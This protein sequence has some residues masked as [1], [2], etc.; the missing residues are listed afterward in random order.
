MVSY[1]RQYLNQG[2]VNALIGTLYFQ[3]AST[4]AEQLVQMIWSSIA[5]DLNNSGLNAG[6]SYGKY[7]ASYS[8]TGNSAME[9][10]DELDV[11]YD[12][13]PVI[14]QFVNAI[15]S[16]G[17][18]AADFNAC[19]DLLFAT[20]T[21]SDDIACSLANQNQTAIFVSC[22]ADDYLRYTEFKNRL[23]QMKVYL[24][25]MK[26]ELF[27]DCYYSYY[28]TYCGDVANTIGMMLPGSAPTQ[29]E[30]DERAVRL[31]DLKELILSSGDVTFA[32]GYVFF[33]CLVYSG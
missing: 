10:Y 3:Q 23:G 27:S 6:S 33:C 5:T 2:F 11:I 32:Q 25:Q 21:L 30:L 28:T 8:F 18:V 29:A 9:Y 16:T 24:Q 26:N 31:R 22:V 15:G 14:R 19:C 12:L 13:E 17:N 1:C 7:I 20:A 4:H